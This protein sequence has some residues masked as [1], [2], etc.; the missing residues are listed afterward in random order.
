MKN[1]NCTTCKYMLATNT[2]IAR[3]RLNQTSNE[4]IYTVCKHPNN[5]FHHIAPVGP[6]LYSAPSIK[7][8]ASGNCAYHET[9]L[10]KL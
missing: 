8:I 9:L 3:I 1:K 5:K 10:L 4:I 7:Q 6:P 2:T